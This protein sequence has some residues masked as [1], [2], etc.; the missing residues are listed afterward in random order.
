MAEADGAGAPPAGEHAA[1]HAGHAAGQ[2]P[3]EAL[4]TP[5]TDS[6]PDTVDGVAFARLY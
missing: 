5:A 2:T 4:T 3:G 1:S 6:T